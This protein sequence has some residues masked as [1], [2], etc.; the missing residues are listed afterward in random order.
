MIHVLVEKR[1]LPWGFFFSLAAR[2]AMKRDKILAWHFGDRCLNY[3][4]NRVMRIGVRQ[5]FKPQHKNNKLIMCQCGLHA[6]IDIMDALTY[7]RG[8]IIRRVEIS[9]SKIIKPDKIC[10]EYRKTIWAIPGEKLLIRF[11]CFCALD[12]KENWKT[13]I[14]DILLRWLRTQD[15]GIRDAARNAARNATQNAAKSSAERA[16]WSAAWSA[17]ESAAQSITEGATWNAAEGVTWGAA[18]NAARNATRSAARGAG[19]GITWSATRSAAEG[20]TWNA[21]RNTAECV[22]WSATEG[23]QRQ[24]LLK[25]I[26]AEKQRKP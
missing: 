21:A 2:C 17:T 12:V 9:G 14:P 16:A 5:R 24:Q 6:S 26:Y 8:E 13:P 4:D 3:G 19:E 1:Q 11:A 20:I 23:Y 25:M 10:A 7:A 15:E 22:A 18:R